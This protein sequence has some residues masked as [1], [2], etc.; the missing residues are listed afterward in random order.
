MAPRYRSPEMD[1]PNEI[2]VADHT[3]FGSGSTLGDSKFMG[4]PP[5]KKQKK[6]GRPAKKQKPMGVREIYRKRSD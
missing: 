3:E 2:G 5:A 4:S 1:R 6:M